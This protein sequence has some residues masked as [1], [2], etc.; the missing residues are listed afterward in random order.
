MAKTPRPAREP[1]RDALRLP[2]ALLLGRFELMGRFTAEFEAPPRER[3][4]A[5]LRAR[6][7]QALRI[8]ARASRWRLVVTILLGF[9]VVAAGV[10]SALDI[11][12]GLGT[13]GDPAARAAVQGLVGLLAVVQALAGSA[14]V[15]L[16][17]AR[18]LLDRYIDAAT[19]AANMLA[20]QLASTA[21]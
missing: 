12:Q 11:A 1:E 4:G 15:L 21:R 20:A 19:T 10:A 5:A 16:L 17:V 9:S 2:G 8:G 14:A 3:D 7:A 6:W 13:A 18:L